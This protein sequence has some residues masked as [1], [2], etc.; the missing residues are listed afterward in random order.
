MNKVIDRM[1][2]TLGL[3]L[4]FGGT[5]ASAETMDELTVKPT[6]RYRMQQ[7]VKV[8][9]NLIL[10]KA[11]RAGI[12]LYGDDP[13]GRQLLQSRVTNAEG[14][15]H[16]SMLIP[17]YL[18]KVLVRARYRGEVADLL[19]PVQDRTIVATIDLTAP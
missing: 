8:D 11:G 4:M 5:V 19:V 13:D 14:Q 1:V 15:Y 7:M 10:P 2:L 3:L 18:T 17:A 16:G 12:V 6:F 9:V